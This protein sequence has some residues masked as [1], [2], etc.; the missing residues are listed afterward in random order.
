MLG[1]NFKNSV[2]KR[3]ASAGFHDKLHDVETATTR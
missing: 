3:L 1:E 2:L